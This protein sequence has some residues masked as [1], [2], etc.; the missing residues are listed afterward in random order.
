MARR[1]ITLYYDV[2]NRT[3]RSSDGFEID[4]ANIPYIHYRE[5]CLVNLTLVT[6]SDLTAYT[7]LSA[8]DTFSATVNNKFNDST[9]MVKTQ[10]ANIN[11]AGDWGTAGGTADVAQGQISIRLDANTTVFDSVMG[12]LEEYLT[13]KF[14][15]QQYDASS[16]LIG[17]YQFTFRCRAIQDEAGATSPNTPSNYYTKSQA[18]TLFMTR[19]FDNPLT[20]TNNATTDIV[21]GAVAT[22]R[23]FIVSGVIDNGTEFNSVEFIITHDGTN[24]YVQH[25]QYDD[26]GTLLADD[27]LSVTASV[28]GAN[29]E[30]ELTLTSFASNLDFIY[31]VYGMAEV[32]S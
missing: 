30:L 18:D 25:T 17:V 3:L 6:D 9:L 32:S 16:L 21:L 13:T 2:V 22:Y 29:L 15:L 23:R 14:E 24:G 27:E 7:E 12:E 31:E 11:L 28:N 10:N 5:Q 1:L 4:E 19:V 26:T 8:T 20:I